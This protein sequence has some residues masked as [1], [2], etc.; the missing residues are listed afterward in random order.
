[1]ER[2]VHPPHNGE[3][4]RRPARRHRGNH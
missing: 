2:L 3:K 4:N 1:V